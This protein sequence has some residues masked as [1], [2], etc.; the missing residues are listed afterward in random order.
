VDRRSFLKLVGSA[1]ALSAGGIALLEVLAPTER[2]FFLP[3]EGGWNHRGQVLWHR[4]EIKNW[5]PEAIEVQ[6]A[7]QNTWLFQAHPLR[8]L[9]G[10][11]LMWDSPH[12]FKPR[13]RINDALLVRDHAYW[14]RA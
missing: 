2:T 14:V 6:T 5:S 13:G 11:S 9:P 7:A 4:W 10:R 1:T 3:P 12:D 8:L